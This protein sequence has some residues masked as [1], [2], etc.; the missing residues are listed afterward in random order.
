MSD[1]KI[2]HDHLKGVSCDAQHC[3]YQ[4]SGMCSAKRI[5]VQSEMAA[6]KADTFCSTFTAAH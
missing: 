6:H 2:Y 1:I 4:E 3:K 5:S